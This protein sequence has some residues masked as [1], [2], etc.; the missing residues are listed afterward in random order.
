MIDN[1]FEPVG[2]GIGILPDVFSYPV[3]RHKLPILYFA[4]INNG[5]AVEVATNMVVFM[6]DQVL[7]EFGD[8]DNL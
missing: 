7:V 6:F 1:Q 2:V 3:Y 4:G 5:F 8:V